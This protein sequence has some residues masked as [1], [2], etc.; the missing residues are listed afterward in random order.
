MKRFIDVLVPSPTCN[1]CCH[2][3]YVPQEIKQSKVSSFLYEPKHI[4]LALSKKRLGGVCH[5]N[6]CGMGETLIPKQVLDITREILKNGHYVMIVTN[7]T[8]TERFHQFTRLPMKL[9]DRLGFKFSFHYLELVK[10][11]LL[12]LFFDN[13]DL[14]KK[15]GMSFSVE[16]TPSD[17]LEPYIEEIKRISRS[18]VGALP[19]LTIPRD[20][21][22]SDIVLLSKYSLDEFIK[23]WKGFDSE[24]LR[25]KKS[26]WGIKR[27]EYCY[28]GAWSGL[29]NIGNGILTACYGS[30]ITQ[31]IFEDL[32]KPIM[33]VAVGKGCNL[34]H[35][36]NSH[37]LLTLGNIPKIKGVYANIRN[38]K[39]EK[40]GS[41]WLK[42]NMK[43]FLS[44]R[45]ENYN[46]QFT[47]IEKLKNYTRKKRIENKK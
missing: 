34:P 17:E 14:V 2:Y 45:L 35:C 6:I 19:H 13:I 28:A 47:L 33:F 22:V 25:F 30:K 12:D 31:N 24:M 39:N 23:K 11:G 1:L 18:R 41:E 42:P 9:R 7:G 38:R 32:K 16:I 5:F 40:D 15:S 3:C 20:M 27:C 46:K 36:Y 10:R 4:G 8:L 44:H 43:K 26:T 37:S 29:L 21:K